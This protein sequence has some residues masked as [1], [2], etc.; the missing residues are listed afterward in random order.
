MTNR[1]RYDQIFID[2]LKLAAEELPAARQGET[3]AWDSLG[4]MGLI[5]ALEDAFDI[6]LE[7]EEILGL[8]SYTAGAE[9]LR[10][11]GIEL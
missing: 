9:L 1:Q 8:D 7:P 6:E 4:Q 10:A 11:R 3:E 2:T 5:A